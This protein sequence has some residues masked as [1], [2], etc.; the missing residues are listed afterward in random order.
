MFFIAIGLWLFLVPMLVVLAVVCGRRTRFWSAVQKKRNL[1]GAAFAT[2]HV[3]FLGYMTYGILTTADPVW[4]MIWLIVAAF[5]FPVSLLLFAVEAVIPLPQ[6]SIMHLVA[7]TGSRLNDLN[8]F[9]IPFVFYLTAGTALWFVLPRM[10]IGR[11]TEVG[12][13]QDINRDEQPAPPPFGR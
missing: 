6:F 4:P 7:D 12:R 10:V 1:V 2:S 13:K 9:W 8:N 3:L 11:S 5:D